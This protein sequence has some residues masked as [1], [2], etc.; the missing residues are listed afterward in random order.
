MQKKRKLMKRTVKVKEFEPVFF[1]KLY[2][3]ADNGVSGTIGWSGASR[4]S[5]VYGQIKMPVFSQLSYTKK[6]KHITRINHEQLSSMLSY[7]ITLNEQV[8]LLL[9][10]PMIN[11]GRWTASLSARAALEVTW[12]VIEQLKIPYIMIDSKDWQSELL[13]R[14]I[15]GAENLKKASRQI[16]NQLFPSVN[17]IPDADGILIAEYARMKGL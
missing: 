13:P 14:G 7:L 4:G 2:I 8:L 1:N 10:R 12:L 3:G 5:H 17:C 6:E 16:G 15:K 9:E 11:P